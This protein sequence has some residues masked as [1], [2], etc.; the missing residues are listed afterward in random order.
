M[1]YFLYLLLCILI[2]ACGGSQTS[3]TRSTNRM[4][5]TEIREKLKNQKYFYWVRLR[6]F[7]VD[8]TG[9]IAF[10]VEILTKSKRATLTQRKLLFLMLIVV[11][12]PPHISP[13]KNTKKIRMPHDIRIPLK[14]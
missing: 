9:I 12:S 11:L 4:T 10:Q 3:D 1:K 2:V 14:E 6:G 8:A 13:F 5:K 7:H